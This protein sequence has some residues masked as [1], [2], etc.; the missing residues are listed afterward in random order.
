MALESAPRVSAGR[1]ACECL[2]VCTLVRHF[3]ID[4]ALGAP[5][6]YGRMHF[7][8]GKEPQWGITLSSRI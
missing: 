8:L 6:C 2:P 1:A 4:S 7:P 3:Q 5:G